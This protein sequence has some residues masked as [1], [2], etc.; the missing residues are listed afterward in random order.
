MKNMDVLKRLM[1]CSQY[2]ASDDNVDVQTDMAVTMEEDYDHEGAIYYVIAVL[3]VYSLS[4]FL[5]IMSM[6]KKTRSQ[7]EI[8]SYLDNMGSIREQEKKQLKHK[9]WLVLHNNPTQ[10]FTFPMPE[11]K[12]A[13]YQGQIL[14]LAPMKPGCE[15]RRLGMLGVIDEAADDT[16][17]DENG[18]RSSSVSTV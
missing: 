2:D 9:T 4:I 16:E 18:S 12:C 15:E 7:E 17:A 14:R 8:E 10:H 5:F 11:P 3:L 1:N 13:T 6:I